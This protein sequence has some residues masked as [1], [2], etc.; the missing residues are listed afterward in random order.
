MIVTN[1]SNNYGPYQFPEKLIP[2]VILKALL[3]ERIPVY[4]DGLNVRD[5]LHV[6]DHCSALE[7]VLRNGKP[8]QAYNVGGNSELQN[9]ELVRQI[10]KLLDELQPCDDVRSY[11]SLITFVTDRPGHDQRYAFDS[12]KFMR[13]LAGARNII[14]KPDCGKPSAGISR[15]ATGGE[16]FLMVLTNSS[17]LAKLPLSRLDKNS[18]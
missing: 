5:W 1:C 12:T 10:C 8:G 14:A 15:T 7:F 18:Q 17:A 6:D 3:L 13:N 11:S 9:I 2:V 16:R 4:G